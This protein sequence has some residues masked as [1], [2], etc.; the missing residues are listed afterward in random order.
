M[1]SLPQTPATKIVNVAIPPVENGPTPVSDK[2]AGSPG[3]KD[4]AILREGQSDAIRPEPD[5][6]IAWCASGPGT[7]TGLDPLRDRLRDERRTFVLLIDNLRLQARGTDTAKLK[8][9]GQSCADTGSYGGSRWC[10]QAWVGRL[11][12]WRQ[13]NRHLFRAFINRHAVL[14][15][16][17]LVFAL[18]W[19]P[20]LIIWGT[21]FLTGGALGTGD[22]L[23]SMADP[24]LFWWLAILSGPLIIALAG[25]LVIALASGRVGL[26]DLRS[27]LFRWRVGV[28][29]YAVSLLTYPL[30]MTAILGA[31]SLSSLAFLPA[32]ITAEDKASLLVAGLVGG[33]VVGLVAS[34]FEEIGWTGFATAE[35][36][37]RHGLLATGLIVGL[38]W[39]V[40]HVPVYAA[41]ASGAVPPALN[42]A[43][44]IFYMLAYRVL[45][46]WVYD[47]TQ[48]V[49][50][51]ILM[52][53]MI[54][55]WPFIL[56]GSPAM[57]G[58]PDLIFNLVLGATL[59]V[60]VAAVMMANRRKLSRG[61]RTRATPLP[62]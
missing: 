53:L 61:E 11:K 29:W 22:E 10:F 36:S 19:G 39:M 45:M 20:G 47:R 32:I 51:A 5:A 35:L 48:S 30:L 57:V 13:G 37:K 43:A 58:V 15:Y 41:I 38:P 18:S 7:I 33:L 14:T 9:A 42:A 23:T 59:W 49:L 56:P 17:T 4:P 60:V 8:A 50:M 26:R 16:F 52:H 34:F 62:A 3:S 6:S 2:M 27:R 28:R 12:P 40:L 55:V 1:I 54:I 24:G 44:I 31:F 25:I 46:V 21:A